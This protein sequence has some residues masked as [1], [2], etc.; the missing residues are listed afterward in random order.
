M[1]LGSCCAA[2]T[3]R[4]VS[5]TINIMIITVRWLRVSTGEGRCRFVAA[6]VTA[7]VCGA[8]D[9]DWRW[10]PCF[11]YRGEMREE[12]QVHGMRL[13]TAMVS[14]LHGEVGEGMSACVCVG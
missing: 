12:K 7:S 2:V 5:L 1:T 3:S 9:D 14:E 10:L 13:D 4:R 11:G 8:S 6:A